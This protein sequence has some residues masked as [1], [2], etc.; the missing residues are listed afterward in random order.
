MIWAVLGLLAGIVWLYFWL[1]GNWFA[2]ILAMPLGAYLFLMFRAMGLRP[3]DT[4]T[5]LTWAGLVLCGILIPA[6]PFTIRHEITEDRARKRISGVT[7]N[8]QQ[9]ARF[10]G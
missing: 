10:N 3:G 2:A 7:L 1:K 5:E 6:A 9:D 8:K 4:F